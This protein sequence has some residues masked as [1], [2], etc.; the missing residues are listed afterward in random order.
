[1][2]SQSQTAYTVNE[3]LAEE[4]SAYYKAVYPLGVKVPKE[5]AITMKL[6]QMYKKKDKDTIKNEVRTNVDDIFKIVKADY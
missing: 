4:I 2:L 3:K 6:K 5:R 1:M